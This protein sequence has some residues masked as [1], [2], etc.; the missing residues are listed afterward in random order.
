MLTLLATIKMDDETAALILS[1]QL[2]DLQERKSKVKRKGREDEGQADTDLAL[3][4]QQEEYE[5]AAP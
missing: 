3:R 2:D 5:E 4:I 1:L